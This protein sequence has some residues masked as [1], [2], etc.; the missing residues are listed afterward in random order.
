LPAYAAQNGKGP[1]K[2]FRPADYPPARFRVTEAEHVLGGLKVRLI[3][4]KE[5]SGTTFVCRGWIEIRPAGGAPKWIER[6]DLEPVGSSFGLFVPSHQPSRELFLIV[7]LKNYDGNLLLIDK[8]G[9]LRQV[10][11]G[12]YFVDLPHRL[13]FSRSFSDVP[14]FLAVIELDTG[15]TVFQGINEEIVRWYR[16]GADLFLIKA[17]LEGPVRQTGYFFDFA[18]KIFQTRKVTPEM[19]SRAEPVDNDFD[20]RWY[21]DCTSEPRWVGP[22]ICRAAGYEPPTICTPEELMGD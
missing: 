8:K 15:K 18:T 17:N 10:P 4:A 9:T 11:G 3:Q 14:P 20:P 12:S 19:W 1:E 5:K 22:E 16:I 2:P 7:E 13:L 6:G 21:Q